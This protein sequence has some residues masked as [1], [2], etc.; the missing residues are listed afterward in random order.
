MVSTNACRSVQK[1][2]DLGRLGI[3]QIEGLT[4]VGEDLLVLDGSRNE[5][6]WVKGW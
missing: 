3:R 1:R 6:V 5:L 4:V 2:I